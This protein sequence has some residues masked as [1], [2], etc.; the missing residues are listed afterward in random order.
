MNSFVAIYSGNGTYNSSTSST[1]NYV[2][3]SPP[4][5]P[6]SVVASVTNG[7]AVVSWAA[8]SG[9]GGFTV[10]GY[11]ATA[12]QGGES[13][14][15]ASPLLSCTIYGLPTGVAE[16]FSVTATSAGG[17][18]APGTSS[19]HTPTL[20]SSTTTLSALTLSPQNAGV[21]VTFAAIVTSGATGYVKFV[22]GS[23]TL[24]AT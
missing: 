3:I 11:T 10:L 23:T 17:T 6:S 15:V 2:G 16:T 4:T 14:T 7:Y 13:C 22:E 12:V 21:P 18:S 1:L 5:A 8:S 24:C 19:S 9:T 20:A